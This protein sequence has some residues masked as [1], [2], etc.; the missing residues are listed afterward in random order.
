MMQNDKP[1]CGLNL[2]ALMVL[3]ARL[4]VASMGIGVMYL[5]G[6]H[7]PAPGVWFAVGMFVIGL[8]LIPWGRGR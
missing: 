8:A 5:E 4:A 6:Q 2:M 1:K 3:F 7:Q